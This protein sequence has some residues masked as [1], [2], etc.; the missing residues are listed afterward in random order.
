MINICCI[1]KIYIILPLVKY[2]PNQ[3]NQKV[4]VLFRPKRG[5]KLQT[6]LQLACEATQKPENYMFGNEFGRRTCLYPLWGGVNHRKKAVI[7][8]LTI[9]IFL[10]VTEFFRYDFKMFFGS[11]IMI[12][13]SKKII[14]WSKQIILWSNHFFVVK[15]KINF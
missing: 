5:S 2:N 13:W 3:T 4:Q 7:E 10:Y 15:T 6:A 14:F 12:L 8:K 9:P 11:K 1:G